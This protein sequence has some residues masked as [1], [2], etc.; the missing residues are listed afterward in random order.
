[1]AYT[2]PGVTTEVQIANNIVQ[3]PG[4]TRVLSIIGTGK[5][6]LDVTGET[7][8]QTTT[9][10]S[11][12]LAHSGVNTISAVYDFTGNGGARKNYPT[13]GS[14]IYGGGYFSTG[15]HLQFAVDQNP[16]PAST[17]PNTGVSYTINYEYS[18]TSVNGTGLLV[19]ISAGTHSTILPTF[20]GTGVSS[21]IQIPNLTTINA[22]Y[23][24]NNDTSGIWV[25]SFDGSGQGWIQSGTSLMWTNGGDYNDFAAAIA[26][27]SIPDSGVNYYVD[28]SYTGTASS[29]L[30]QNAVRTQVITFTGNIASGN[31]F[32]TGV[33]N[34]GVNY[35]S[36]TLVY[37]ESGTTTGYDSL[38]FGKDGSGWGMTGT[39]QGSQFIDWSAVNPTGA[40]GYAYANTPPTGGSYFVNYSYNKTGTDYNPKN[41]VDYSLVVSEYGPEAEWQLQT[42]GANIGN[43][44]FL[45]LNPVTLA[46]R[47]AF[48]NGAPIVNITQMKGA[49]DTVGDFSVALNKLQ[50]ITTDL[51]VPLTVASG[52]TAND[53]STATIS[54][55]LSETLLH[56]QTMSSAQNKKERVSIGSL[57]SAEIGDADT[58]ETY[59]FAAQTSLNDERATLI[60]PGKVTVQIQDPQ[61]KFQNIEVNSAFLAVAYAA[62]SASSLS[63]VATPLTNQRLSNFIDISAETEDHPDDKYL[64]VEKNV[65]GGAGVAVIDRLGSNIYVRHQLTTDQSNEAVGE[66]SVVTLK[67]FVSQAVRFT[68]EG[69]IGKKLI[70]A[71]VVPAVKSTILATMQELAQEA[72][73]SAIGAITVT[74]NPTN[75]TEILATVEYVPVFPFN[76]LKVTFTIRTQL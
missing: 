31:S 3:L 1:M 35:V 19:D 75:A 13:T 5:G 71:I 9:R 8:A 60:A 41:F 44:E 37:P 22:V 11:A 16:Y 49:G 43:Y 47:L 15:N 6:T 76:R 25:P 39:T 48:A 58:A 2:P 26:A 38:G 14:T 20:S 7:V 63:D 46:A 56:C 53:L 18:G 57:G 40:Y 52:V 10:I 55:I 64:E 69:F 28:Y 21:A 27:D 17:T 29:T 59:V 45:H 62:L 42:S 65:L 51:I 24:G 12:D 73:I 30:T 4:G 67:D 74:V 72:I 50:N 54:S 34:V 36:G 68:T 23:S 32:V 33:S 66:F 70:P 61:G